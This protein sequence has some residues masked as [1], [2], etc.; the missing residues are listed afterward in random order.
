MLHYVRVYTRSAV[1]SN[2]CDVYFYFNGVLFSK[3]KMK[4]LGS[5]RGNGYVTLGRGDK[6]EYAHRIVWEMHCGEIPDN[7]EIDHINHNNSDNRIENLRLVTKQENLKNKSKH[8]NN[9]SGITGVSIMRGKN[10]YTYFLAKI[11]VNGSVVQKTFKNA[12]DAMLQR[13]EWDVAFKMH[14]NHGA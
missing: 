1:M 6:T 4:P 2:W 14:K 5:I 11:K 8:K 9:T 10:G 7:M 3:A 13:I 12:T